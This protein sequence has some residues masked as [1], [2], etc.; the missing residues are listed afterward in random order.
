MPRFYDFSLKT[1]KAAEHRVCSRCSICDRPTRGPNN[2]PPFYKGDGQ[3][4][5]IH[6]G[7]SGRGKAPRPSTSMTMGELKSRDNCIWLC[8]PCHNSV[9]SETSVWTAEE[10][11][12][13]RTHAEQLARW[14]LT[15]KIPPS[16]WDVIGPLHKH[17][18]SNPNGEIKLRARTVRGWIFKNPLLIEVPL[19]DVPLR[20]R[21]SAL[22][23]E[24]VRLAVQEAGELDVGVNRPVLHAPGVWAGKLMAGALALP[25]SALHSFLEA[26]QALQ[27]DGTLMYSERKQG[28]WGE[29]T[30]R[31]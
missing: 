22:D 6:S 18:R 26:E 8:S 4:A 27:V 14:R 13:R 9:D 24:G 21:I 15:G 3:A 1:K 10:L 29:W 23:H 20:A 5:H 30:F 12:D 16:G 11:V 25:M 31:P 28:S 7:G 2:D 17:F 19:S